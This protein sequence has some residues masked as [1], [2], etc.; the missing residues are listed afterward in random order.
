MNWVII[1]IIVL[2]LWLIIS[3]FSFNSIHRNRT[4]TNK[5]DKIRI[6]KHYPEIVNKINLNND[7]PN[8]FRWS[9][10]WISDWFGKYAEIISDSNLGY[11]KANFFSSKAPEISWCYTYSI[12]III[13]NNLVTFAIKNIYYDNFLCKNEQELDSR[14]NNNLRGIVNSY[15]NFIFSNCSA[16]EYNESTKTKNQSEDLITFYRNLLE[17]KINFTHNELKHAYREAVKK[18][19]PDKYNTLDSRNIENAEILLKQINEAYEAL[20]KYAK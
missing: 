1:G 13:K 18:Y 14:V 20:K 16:E 10:I 15:K 6:S 17:L 11:I 7:D 4:G 8:V 5:N 2:V 3:P 12:E 19:H 9:K